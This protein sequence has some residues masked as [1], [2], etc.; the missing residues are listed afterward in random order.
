MYKSFEGV[1]KVK[2]IKKS[3][4]DNNRSVLQRSGK[5][6]TLDNRSSKINN[7]LSPQKLNHI[8]FRSAN[9]SELKHHPNM[10]SQNQISINNGII[11]LV[12]L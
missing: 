12:N 2:M 11:N 10:Y 5:E 3:R 8:N 4:K 9:K 6:I 1:T 7:D